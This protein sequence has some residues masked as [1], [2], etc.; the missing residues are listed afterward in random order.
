MNRILRYAAAGLAL[1]LILGACTVTT[2]LDGELTGRV[3]FETPVRADQVITEFRPTRGAGSIYRVGEDI[4]FTI[5]SNRAGYVT[6]SYLDSNG[7]FGTFARNIFVPRGRT[8]IS[9]PDARHYF[10]VA[11]PRGP[12]QIRASFTADRTDEATLSFVGRGG[13]SGWNSMLILDLR[14]QP[15]YDAVQT[16]IEVR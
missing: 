11:E 15:V 14:G 6:L 16:F 12:M 8:T 5:R 3:R 1:V 7:N 13:T 2:R 4:S 9:G 10:S